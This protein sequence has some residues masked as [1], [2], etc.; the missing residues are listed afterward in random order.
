[1]QAELSTLKT[2]ILQSLNKKADFSMLDRLNELVAKKVD[3]EH[4]KQSQVTLKT[5]LTQDLQ[6]LRQEINVDRASREQ[7][8]LE[9]V[10]SLS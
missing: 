6:L 9:K 7:R 10:E 5:E 4:L 1:M 3:T 2:S 8:V